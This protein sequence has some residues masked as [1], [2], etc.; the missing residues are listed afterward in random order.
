MAAQAAE[1]A[2]RTSYGRLVALL[3]WRWH[4][5]AAAEDALADALLAALTHWPRDG[6]PAAPD[7]W[8]MTVANRRMLQRARHAKLAQDPAFMV[9]FASESQAPEMPAVPDKRLE[10]MFVCAHPALPAKMHTPLMLQAVLGLDAQA[11][12][13][14]FLVSPAALAQRLVRV[15]A[16]IRSLA[17]RFELPESAELPARLAAVLESLYGAYTIGSNT[18]RHGPDAAAG[19]MADL[20]AEAL[21]L[22]RLVVALQ[23]QSAE[24]LGLLALMLHNE[25]RRPA[26]FDAGGGFVPLTHQDTQRWQHTL[27]QEAEQALWQ[28]A[29]LRQPGAFQIEAAIHSAHAQRA[30][31]GRTPWA[32]IAALYGALVQRVPAIG[33]R[34]GHAV[35]LAESGELAAGQAALDALTSDSVGTHAPYWVALAHLRRLAGDKS[36]AAQALDRAIGL[37]EDPRV[38][39]HLAAQRAL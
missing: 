1:H 6:V 27:L 24:A 35:A 28:A 29:Q 30:F 37:T 16:Q 19:T 38:R 4:D 25:A 33:A 13:S 31:G 32:A 12:A 36:G 2:A 39:A 8:L 18:A 7:A 34:I 3:A 22:A 5:L 11:I 10:L 20:A 15:K 14:A 9:L 21:F 26:Q 23:P 17:L